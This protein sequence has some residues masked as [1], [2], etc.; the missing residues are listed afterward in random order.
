MFCHL[1]SFP[2]PCTELLQQQAQQTQTQCPSNEQ[3]S[4]GSA[5]SPFAGSNPLAV[6]DTHPGFPL[7][8]KVLVP[9]PELPVTTRFVWELIHSLCPTWGRYFCPVPSR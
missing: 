3:Q 6:H 4:S 9:L 2:E 1:R 8:S 5:H 7:G